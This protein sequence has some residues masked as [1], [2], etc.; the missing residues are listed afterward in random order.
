MLRSISGNQR[1]APGT[2]VYAYSL[3][4]SDRQRYAVTD[5]PHTRCSLWSARIQTHTC[6]GR[7]VA[8]AVKPHWS[9]TKRMDC[10]GFD[11]WVRQR[12]EAFRIVYPH[13]RNPNGVGDSALL[14]L[15]AL[16]EPNVEAIKS[17]HYHGNKS[18]KNYGSAKLD[19]FG[20]ASVQRNVAS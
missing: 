13:L 5:L 7:A 20:V 9:V 2:G 16:P 8:I 11:Y 14:T 19:Q 4:C 3:E 10:S 6:C 12:V 15:D 18:F 17:L 1:D